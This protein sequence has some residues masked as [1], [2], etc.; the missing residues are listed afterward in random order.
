MHDLGELWI[1]QEA[2]TITYSRKVPSVRR[3]VQSG[4]SET[5]ELLADVGRV[6]GHQRTHWR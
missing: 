4:R 6:P 2:Y 1:T 5:P 3:P